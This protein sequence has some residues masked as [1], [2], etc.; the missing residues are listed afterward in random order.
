VSEPSFTQLEDT[1][2][3][4][5]QDYLGLQKVATNATLSLEE[6]GSDPLEVLLITDRG[7]PIVKRVRNATR[8]QVVKV[9]QEFRNDLTSRRSR[10]YLASA[11]QLYRW[12]VAPLEEDLRSQEI[13]N[14]VFIM[15]TGL[16][17]LPLA[18]LHD[19]SD[20]IIAN[21][22]VGLM[23]SL[24]LTDTRYAN[25]KNE[26]VLAMGASR[27]SDQN[28]LPAVSTE[29]S[30]ITQQLWTGR[31]FL[32]E[33]FTLE[34]LQQARA[35]QPF[36]I[37][38]LATHA[39]FQPGMPNN[40]YIQLWNTKL[41]LNQLRQ[42]G[43][44]NPSV[45]LLVLSACRTALG[46]KNAELGFAGLAVQAGV[47]SGLGSLW[48][49]ND[50]GTLA[51]MTEFYEQLK[52]AP[53]KAEAL[54][55]AQLAMLKGNVRLEGETLMTTRNKFPLPPELAQLGSPDLSHPYYW[56]AFTMIGNPW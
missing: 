23:P 16:R 28:P 49:V 4:D 31:S 54:R 8:S 32:N 37:V 36:G 41:T 1:L 34:N 10:A 25:V 51:F 21:Y 11:K 44:N 40:S 9:A 50:E 47:K 45:E 56:S 46:D 12:F 24:S 55:Q 33:A 27:F 7:K 30:V 29:L 39:E 38:H 42:F 3:Q 6:Q 22:S 5:F 2:T 15:D 18:A 20:F 52:Q 26:Q 14:L 48:Y 13:K 43:L 53:I 19:G 35:Q 17:S